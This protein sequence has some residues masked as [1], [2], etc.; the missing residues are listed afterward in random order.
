MR[1]SALHGAKAVAVLDRSENFGGEYG[2]VGL[3]VA[4]ALYNAKEN[5]PLKNY[6]FGL[7]GHDVTLEQMEQV[8]E[9]LEK[10]AAGTIDGSIEYLGNR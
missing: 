8:Y 5:I 2:P 4:T 9:D 3:E 10:L 7:G 1:V 6:M